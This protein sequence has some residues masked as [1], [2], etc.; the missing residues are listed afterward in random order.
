[1]K[2]GESIL[3]SKYK[4]NEIYAGDIGIFKK[5]SMASDIGSDITFYFGGGK[6]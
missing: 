1:M 5:F 3:I 2:N 6:L 4:K